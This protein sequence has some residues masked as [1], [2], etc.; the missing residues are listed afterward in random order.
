[1]PPKKDAKGT[2]DNK[3]S[4]SKKGGAAI[5]EEKG[6]NIIFQLFV[7]YNLKLYR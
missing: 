2:K 5:S 6:S 4:G 7:S 1:M 3:A